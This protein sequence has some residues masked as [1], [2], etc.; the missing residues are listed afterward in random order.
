M[1]LIYLFKKLKF[2]Y[3]AENPH[4]LYAKFTTYKK[5][6]W[7]LKLAVKFNKKYT[8]CEVFRIEYKHL[9][10]FVVIGL[11]WNGKVVKRRTSGFAKYNVKKKGDMKC[12]YCDRQ[13][14]DENATSDHIVPISKRGNNAQVNLV[15]SCRDC[16]SDRGNMEF[17]KYLRMKNKALTYKEYLFV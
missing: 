6:K 11:K 5:W 14:T 2:I 8:P 3:K 9:K 7:L 16:N 15:V 1:G 17:Y 4:F 12:I 13:L 10:E